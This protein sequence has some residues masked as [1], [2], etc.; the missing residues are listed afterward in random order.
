MDNLLIIY[1]ISGWTI[2]LML[3]FVAYSGIKNKNLWKGRYLF[4]AIYF[5]WV[6]F[7]NFSAGI[8]ALFNFNNLFFTHLPLSFVLKAMYLKGEHKQQKV[9][10][11]TYVC[12]VIFIIAQ[13]YKTFDAEGYKSMN[14][15]GAY[16]G[17]PFFMIYTVWNLTTMFREKPS[18]QNLRQNPDFWFTAT[19]FAFAF[20]SLVSTVLDETSYANSSDNVLYVLFSAENLINAILYIGYYRGIKLMR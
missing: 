12:I 3:I 7:T 5:C 8:L 15:F 13:L 18:S 17:Y 16:S 11:F 19:M 10:Y 4:I 14:V 6:A 9:H 1:R 2:N 20:V